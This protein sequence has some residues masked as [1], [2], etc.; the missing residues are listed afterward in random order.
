MEKMCQTRDAAVT[1]TSYAYVN[2]VVA[3][4]PGHFIGN[5]ELALRTG[6]EPR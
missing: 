1:V 4:L 5:E 6:S 3:L 2:P